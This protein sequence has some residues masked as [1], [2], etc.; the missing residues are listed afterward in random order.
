MPRDAWFAIAG[1]GAITLGSLL[2]FVSFHAAGVV[3]NSSTKPVATVF[4]LIVVGVGFALGMAP[5]GG[6]IAAGIAAVTLAFLAGLFEVLFI[7]AGIA[8]VPVQDDFGDTVTVTYSPNIGIILSLIGCVAAI[9]GGIMSF[10]RR[11]R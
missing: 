2:P 9:A 4:G 5:R 11:R 10:Q 8:G 6:R 3:V 7:I 1:G